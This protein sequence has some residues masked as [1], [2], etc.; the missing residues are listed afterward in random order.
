MP[1]RGRPVRTIEL[2]A[3][4]RIFLTQLSRRRSAPAF[5][6]K[7]AKAVILMAD[8]LAN[9][10]IAERVGFSKATV[11]TLRKRFSEF[12]LGGISDLPR[13]GP[14]RSIGDDQVRELVEKTLHTKPTGSTH[15]RHKKD[16][17]RDG[18]LS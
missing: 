16:G 14:P 18:D 11:S 4:E 3:D 9:K 6:V 12:R 8:G 7:R 15:W 2:S 17:R 5:E 10:D 1:R 13:S